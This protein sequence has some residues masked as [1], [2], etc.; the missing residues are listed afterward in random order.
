MKNTCYIFL[1]LKTKHYKW[2]SPVNANP[3][4]VESRF[5]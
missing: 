1:V 4:P 2:K 5:A 3:L